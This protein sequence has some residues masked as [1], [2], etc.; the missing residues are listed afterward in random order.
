MKEPQTVT[1]RR[2]PAAPEMSGDRTLPA[3]LSSIAMFLFQINGLTLSYLIFNSPK[4]YR[5]QNSRHCPIEHDLQF[6]FN[7][8][9]INCVSKIASKASRKR[10]F[11]RCFLDFLEENMIL[12]SDG[13]QLPKW[14]YVNC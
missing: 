4:I 8:L 2:N 3:S 5:S 12:M 6:N 11:R 14:Y 9:D 13:G 10:Q 7:Y 1:S